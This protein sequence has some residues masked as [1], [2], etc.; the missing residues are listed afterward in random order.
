MTLSLTARDVILLR[1]NGYDVATSVAVDPNSDKQYKC[2]VRAG[3]EQIMNRPEE[4]LNLLHARTER[5]DKPKEIIR[6][7]APSVRTRTPSKKEI[8]A[9]QI[10]DNARAQVPEQECSVRWTSDG[11]SPAAALIRLMLSRT[12]VA[13]DGQA[14][15]III[16]KNNEL[17]NFADTIDLDL[18][19]KTLGRRD[20]GDFD[21]EASEWYLN[22]DTL[23]SDSIR[24][25][26]KL[27]KL[28][29]KLSLDDTSSKQ[30]DQIIQGLDRRIQ[31]TET[32]Q[33]GLSNIAK[34][35]KALSSFQQ[36]SYR[37]LEHKIKELRSNLLFFVSSFS[38]EGQALLV[39]NLA[40][41]LVDR[42]QK[43]GATVYVLA[44]ESDLMA[45]FTEKFDGSLRKLI[46]DPQF[47]STRLFP[48]ALSRVVGCVQKALEE[49]FGMKLDKFF[50]AIKQTA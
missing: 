21:S 39:Q 40:G 44:T 8:Q 25:K 50:A 16:Q 38:R 37:S 6:E 33:R 5:T 34:S 10:I 3:R 32:C 22:R 41:G 36:T 46:N 13:L 2:I 42:L 17:R 14:A 20:L 35:W 9:K 12:I 49:T 43:S 26:A 11:Q 27:V 19:G 24:L 30:L 18:L 31:E 1:Q 4:V 15:D 7:E 28:K 48:D 29:A 23:N 47:L 45:V